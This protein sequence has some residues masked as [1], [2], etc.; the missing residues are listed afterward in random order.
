MLHFIIGGS[1][2]S[3]D[4]RSRLTSNLHNTY[5]K[6]DAR[7]PGTLL[8]RQLLKQ[9]L[10][11]AKLGDQR[12]IAP[13]ELVTFG[14][15]L[16]VFLRDVSHSTTGTVKACYTDGGEVGILRQGQQKVDSLKLLKLSAKLQV[17]GKSGFPGGLGDAVQVTIQ[18]MHSFVRDYDCCYYAGAH[19]CHGQTTA[20]G[21]H[22]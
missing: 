22:T 18:C 12:L 6:T 19:N 4:R 16:R 14:A 8:G 15:Q 11:F 10:Q 2:S 9:I 21:S 5:H 3:N 20:T 13:F 17:G 7:L 1:H